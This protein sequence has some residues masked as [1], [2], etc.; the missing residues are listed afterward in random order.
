MKRNKI[1][2][3]VSQP[4]DPKIVL[5]KYSDGVDM[6]LETCCYGEDGI[7][8]RATR[9]A[10]TVFALAFTD[11]DI[12]GYET[13]CTALLA[14]TTI[15]K[16]VR[17]EIFSCRNWRTKKFAPDFVKRFKQLRGELFTAISY[18]NRAL[19]DND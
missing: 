8:G 16:L 5:G 19:P 4:V 3:L 13:G 15:R 1:K 17:N 10:D 6:Y 14:K 9:N 11:Y 2:R 7:G 12:P 18:I